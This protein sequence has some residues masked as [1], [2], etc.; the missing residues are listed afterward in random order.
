MGARSSSPENARR[1]RNH[2]VRCSLGVRSIRGPLVTMFGFSRLGFSGAG[3]LGFSCSRAALAR[4]GLFGLPLLSVGMFG[5]GSIAMSPATD[6][7]PWGRETG[8]IGR[9][10]GGCPVGKAVANLVRARRT[11]SDGLTAFAM[12]HDSTRS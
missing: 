9:G 1:M 8:P 11:G 4:P 7:A 6:R 5:P 10:P 12:A 2:L 3:R